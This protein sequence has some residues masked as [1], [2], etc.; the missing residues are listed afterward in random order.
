MKENLHTKYTPFTCN[1]VALNKKLPIT[2]QNL[3]IFFFIIGRVECT[4][5][6]TDN[7]AVSQQIWLGIGLL[8]HLHVFQAL[9]I[10]YV[11]Q[12]LL[13]FYVNISSS[14]LVIKHFVLP[15]WVSMQP[16][17]QFWGECGSLPG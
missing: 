16:A 9:L 7:N 2:K 6:G 13:I 15:L 17:M 4:H 1:D 5:I 14:F 8:M 3:C 10:F 12:A 11:N